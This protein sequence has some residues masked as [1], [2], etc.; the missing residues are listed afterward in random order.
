MQNFQDFVASP[1]PG[2]ALAPTKGGRVYPKARPTTKEFEMIRSIAAAIAALFLV[3]F[4]AKADEA[5][6]KAEAKEKKAEKKVE[7]AEKK[8]DKKAEKA[9]EKA[10]KKVEKAEEKAEKK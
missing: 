4:A 5:S 8:A 3:A 1:T 7:K 2:M 6:A 10:E 9:E